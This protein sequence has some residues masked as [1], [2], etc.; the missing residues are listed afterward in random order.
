MTTVTGLLVQ[1]SVMEENNLEPESVTT[2]LLK[3]GEKTAWGRQ[4]KQE[5]AMKIHVKRKVGKV[6]NVLGR[7]K[8][9]TGFIKYEK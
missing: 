1:K 3:M 5:N 8:S 7:L 2:Q 9:V 6:G 4:L